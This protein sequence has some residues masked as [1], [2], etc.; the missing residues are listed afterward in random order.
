MLYG[1]TKT[2]AVQKFYALQKITIL[3]MCREDKITEIVLKHYPTVQAMYLFGSYAAEVQRP[4]SD[5][6]IALLLP[7]RI[8]KQV[9][10]LAMSDLRFELESALARDVDI[11]NLRR[12]S[13][14][15]QKEIIAEGSRVYV[16]DESAADEFEM[17]TVSKYQKLNEERAE[18][19]QQIL[20]SGRCY[21]V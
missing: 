12:V 10:S 5:V 9:G 11:V 18:I 15:F 2:T 21:E 7:Y 13:T 6:D 3:A 14:V 1:W 20:A 16:A 17:L 8:A 19:L 4:G